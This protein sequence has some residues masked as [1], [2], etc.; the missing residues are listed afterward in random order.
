[1]LLGGGLIAVLGSELVGLGGAG[2]L[3]CIAAA[4]LSCYAWSKQGWD[5]ED[6]S[7]HNF[8]LFIPASF[9]SRYSYLNNSPKINK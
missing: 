2:P 4:F 1:M 5:V 8:N 7:I 9:L 3:G 6:V